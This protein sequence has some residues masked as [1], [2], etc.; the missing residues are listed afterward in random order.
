MA[1]HIVTLDR[2]P[3]V[4]PGPYAPLAVVPG[5]SRMRRQNQMTHEEVIAYN[6]R[7]GGHEFTIFELAQPDRVAKARAIIERLVYR[8]AGSDIVIVEPGC[9]TGDISGY[10]AGL[11]RISVT[12]IDVTPGAAE[13]ARAKW[14]AMTILET[15]IEKV[16]PIP[17][18]ILVLCEFMEHITD[19]V[20]FAKAWLPKARFVVI[21]HPLVGD[22]IDYEPGHP[23]AYYDVDFANWFPLGG[24][25]L[26]EAWE[27][28]M[29]Y[30]MVIGWGERV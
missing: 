3:S 17:C 28:P 14:P 10:F 5:P 26:R 9:S 25:E 21:G 7:G 1:S 29:G 11:P 27:F 22:D 24:H 6:L 19:P 23:W 30:R 8:L 2:T 16:E 13:T 20:A 18:D 15:E 4:L 12:G